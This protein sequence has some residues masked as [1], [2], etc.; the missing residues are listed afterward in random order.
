M[1]KI[2]ALFLALSIL[3]ALAAC[4]S[5]QEG[6]PTG[7]STG[8][9]PATQTTI[10]GTTPET[11]NPSATDPADTTPSTEPSTPPATEPTGTTPP[12]TTPP[13]TTP[14]ATT[15]PTT[16]PPATEPPHNHSYTPSVTKEVTCTED[17]IS[18]YTCAC[19]DTYTETLTAT[20]HTMGGWS[21]YIQGDLYT[22][23]EERNNCTNCSHYESRMQYNNYFMQY[24]DIA[25]ALKDFASP[26]NVALDKL[27][28]PILRNVS[29]ERIGKNEY[30]RTM[31]AY[32]ISDVDTFTLNCLGRTYDFT[33]M[34]KVSDYT[35]G[36]CYY[37]AERNSIIQVM[38][39][40]GDGWETSYRGYTTTDNVH[41]VVKYSYDETLGTIYIE[42]ID[43]KYVMTSHTLE[44]QE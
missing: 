19:G 13:T 33:N 14:P 15:P 6:A 23:G 1:K 10:P 41:F 43:G 2:L 4:G 25:C 22:V 32:K 5:K 36:Y 37:D 9:T 29:Y 17:G 35:D 18:T 30:G 40:G 31:Y 38:G 8:S 27:I 7:E 34:G 28:D 20:G 24:V 11:S 44:N 39:W 42:L 26:D 16:T 21:T 12:A 3:L